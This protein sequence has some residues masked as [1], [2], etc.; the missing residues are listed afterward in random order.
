MRDHYAALGVQ[1]DADFEEIKR[2][3]RAQV[4]LHHPDAG[5]DGIQI[6]EINNAWEILGNSDKRKAYDQTRN[7]VKNTYQTTARPAGGGPRT[8]RTSS[9]WTNQAT[10]NRYDAET[11]AYA[12]KNVEKQIF[13]KICIC[14]CNGYPLTHLAAYSINYKRYVTCPARKLRK[15]IGF[16][17][18]RNG[19]LIS[20]DAAKTRR[21]HARQKSKAESPQIKKDREQA[22]R[23][24]EKEIKEQQ[25]VKE[26]QDRAENGL[27]PTSPS[28][29]TRRGLNYYAGRS[30]KYG[31]ASLRDLKGNCLKCRELEK[32]KRQSEKLSRQATSGK[33]WM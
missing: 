16:Y 12:V 1:R 11:H 29:A 7:A 21:W 24:K 15:K 20:W 23:K 32:M 18:D 2:A 17:Y 22:K 14:G 9:E 27:P 13:K 8:N 19:N 4:K 28:E 26:E 5:G 3:Y 6:L 10:Q 31:H 33:A 25:R 30:C